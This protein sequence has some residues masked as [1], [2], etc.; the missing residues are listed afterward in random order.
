MKCLPHFYG[1]SYLIVLK[2]NARIYEE[3][4]CKT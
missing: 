4:P 3:I 2:Q 1:E